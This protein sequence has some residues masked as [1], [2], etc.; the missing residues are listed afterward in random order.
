MV[1][2]GRRQLLA[3]AVGVFVSGVVTVAVRSGDSSELDHV[4]RRLDSALELG[5][6][7][8]GVQ[9]YYGDLYGPAF[10]GTVERKPVGRV[11]GL[12][13]GRRPEWLPR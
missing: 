8:S 12:E 11:D 4:M 5:S 10:G 2:F 7:S 6:P 9:D 3:A 13:L 1:R